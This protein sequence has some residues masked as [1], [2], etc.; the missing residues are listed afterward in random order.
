MEVE[1]WIKQF[2][3]PFSD[4]SPPIIWKDGKGFS[5]VEDYKNG[6]ASL[7]KFG[8]VNPTS[9]RNVKDLIATVSYGKFVDGSIG[10]GTGLNGIR[11]PLDLDFR[12][13]FFYDQTDKKFFYHENEID[14]KEILLH[15]QKV[16]K[17][18]TQVVRGLL[19]RLRLWYWRSFMPGLIKIIDKILIWIL[20]LI[21]GEQLQEDIWGRLFSQD[22]FEQSDRKIPDRENSFE[23]K[24]VM[25]FFGYEAKRWSVVFFCLLHVSGYVLHYVSP[26]F[27]VDVLVEILS[28]NFLAL[29][30]VVVAF[31]ITESLIPSF[32]RSIILGLNPRAFRGVTFKK[33]KVS[34]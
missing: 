28:N 12:N 3:L 6:F 18:P 21:S 27:K 34:K 1:D 19:L 14:A 2:E 32:L 17:K 33:I 25:N 22:S 8:I 5:T 4:F 11:D 23:K 16:H 7:Y 29:C 15:V 31:A 10:L 20:W 13:E 24:K 30:Y 9:E 26:G